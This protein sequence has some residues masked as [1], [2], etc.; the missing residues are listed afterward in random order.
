M[1]EVRDSN[2]QDVAA[3]A[4]FMA[5]GAVFAWN[6][7]GLAFG[8]GAR[9]GPGYFPTVLS[10]L[11][12][13]LGAAIFLN[14][15]RS[16]KRSEVQIPWK[17]LAIVV[18]S[19]VAFGLLLYPLGFPIAITSAVFLSTLASKRLALKT[20]VATSVGLA[21]LCWAIFV[22]ELGLQLPLWGYWIG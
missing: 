6:S 5:L 4:I 15:R 14:G 16:D 3:G 12:L 21:V 1:N 22:R 2:R 20:A 10:W 9:M 7:H 8:T 13:I 19:P 17:L 18:I 11:L